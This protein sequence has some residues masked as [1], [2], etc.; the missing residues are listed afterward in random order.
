MNQKHGDTI[1]VRQVTK[2]PCQ[3]DQIVA[4]EHYDISTVSK[5]SCFTQLNVTDL[6]CSYELNS[7]RL[8]YYLDRKSRNL[9][10][11]RHE[12]KTSDHRNSV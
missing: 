1:S 6:A 3:S 10:C 7:P 11:L 5:G 2:H 9:R 12:S 4:G 8:V